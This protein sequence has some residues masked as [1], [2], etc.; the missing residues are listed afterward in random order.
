MTYSVVSNSN[1]A[2]VTPSITDER[3]TLTYPTTATAGTS[4]IVVK[5]TNTFGLTVT[6]SFTVTVT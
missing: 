6:Q 1:S 2:V 4:T 3:L 5:A